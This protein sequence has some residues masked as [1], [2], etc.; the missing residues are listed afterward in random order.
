M[1]RTLCLTIDNIGEAAEVGDGSFPPDAPL[2]AHFT[3]AVVGRLLDLLDRLDVPAT[4]F[5]EALNA[6][7]YPALLREI[8]AR[9]HELAC[10]GWQHEHWHGL[11]PAQE[12]EILERC[13]HAL[14][15]LGVRPVGFRPPGGLVTAAT[16]ALL[17]EL[18]Y[19]YHSPAGTSAG[20]A[21]G[22][23]VLPFEWRTVDAFYR[24]P[25]FAGL[26]ERYGAGASLR[27]GMVERLDAATGPTVLV[28][29]PMLLDEPDALAALGD[30]LA[31]RADVECVRM[32]ALA[33]R[34]L[35]DPGAPAPVVDE[36][37]WA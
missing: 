11:T 36:A 26:R 29:H 28:F 5:V 35:A 3:V 13:T 17:R 15:D 27:D 8:V 32:D 37:T 12:R 14:N 23:A 25:V 24:A 22:L 6:R 2:G 30:V 18:G 1:A 33:E 9:G 16:P 4:F 31:A 10:H 7:V 21:D 19:R 20:V 34:L